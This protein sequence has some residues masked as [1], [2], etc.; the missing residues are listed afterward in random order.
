MTNITL[1]F[2]GFC[3]KSYQQEQYLFYNADQTLKGE[4]HS[5]KLSCLH[6]IA[7]KQSAFSLT[8]VSVSGVPA[9]L[10]KFVWK[11]VTRRPSL[12][13]CTYPNQAILCD[14]TPS[15]LKLAGRR[16]I[17][18]W[19]SIIHKASKNRFFLE[20]IIHFM[21]L[22]AVTFGIRSMFSSIKKNYGSRTAMTQSGTVN[23][24]P[25]VTKKI[26]AVNKS[27]MQQPSKVGSLLQTPKS[28]FSNIQ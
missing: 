5:K 18:N 2:H 12:W 22:T 28:R 7:S 10:R 13:N 6:P 14:I 1:Y 26:V 17:C 19:L 9:I 27:W 15:N 21:I 25:E 20:V 4:G 8:K 11:E 3:S 23:P 24:A 16:K